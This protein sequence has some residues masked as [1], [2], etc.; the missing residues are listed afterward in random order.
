MLQGSQLKFGK[1]KYGNIIIE[2]LY[3]PKSVLFHL[4]YSCK[5][6]CKDQNEHLLAW[7]VN[8]YKKIK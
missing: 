2:W 5:I 7:S 1:P 4:F 6:T 3:F 8:N